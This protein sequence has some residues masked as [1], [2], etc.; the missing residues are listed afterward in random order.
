M[1][2]AASA[3]VFGGAAG[4]TIGS[5]IHRC[6]R[7]AAAGLVVVAGVSVLRSGSRLTLAEV[8][9]RATDKTPGR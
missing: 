3:S 2:R 1:K 8:A 5:V 6:G 9:Q 4:L 7:L